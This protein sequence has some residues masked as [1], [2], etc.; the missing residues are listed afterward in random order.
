MLVAH[1]SPLEI[2]F[3]IYYHWCAAKGRDSHH[4]PE[5]PANWDTGDVLSGAFPECA[6]NYGCVHKSVFETVSLSPHSSIVAGSRLLFHSILSRSPSSS[7]ASNSSTKGN[8][9][10]RSLGFA[11]QEGDQN[12]NT[13]GGKDNDGAG[14]G[15]PR[16]MRGKE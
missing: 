8:L 14:R 9:P 13:R 5:R 7:I 2:V 12:E 3:S 16:H 6:V 4:S 1:I 15:N 11:P 10:Q